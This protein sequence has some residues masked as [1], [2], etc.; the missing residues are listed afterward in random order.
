MFNYD[1]YCDYSLLHWYL[2]HEEDNMY[3]VTIISLIRGEWAILGDFNNMYD[4]FCNSGRSVL[5]SAIIECHED[6]GNLRW[7][8]RI[9]L[10]RKGKF[11]E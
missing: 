1:E 3:G 9:D 4:L 10:D 8:I 11:E 6:A 2:D 7:F 5:D